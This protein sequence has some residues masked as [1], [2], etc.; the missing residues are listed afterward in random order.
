MAWRT[1][2]SD[3]LAGILR[4]VARAALLIDLIILAI[5]ST[6]LTYKLCDKGM[7]YLDAW[8]FAK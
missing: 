2:V 4:F 6:W 7:H 5:F 1:T 8:L 3:V